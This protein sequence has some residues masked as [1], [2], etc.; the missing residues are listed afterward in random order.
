MFDP[1][2]IA[3]L[4][5]VAQ[6]AAQV[7]KTRMT[8][9]LWLKQGVKVAG[10]SHKL[11]GVRLGRN[12]MIHPEQLAAFLAGMNPRAAKPETPAR[13]KTR[14]QDGQARAAAILRGGAQ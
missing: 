11:D 9:H 12:W 1:N 5:T 3:K 14:L 13:R 6:V 4:M 10:E 2:E 7:R 8:V